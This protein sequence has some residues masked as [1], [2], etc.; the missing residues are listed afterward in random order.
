MRILYYD[1]FAGISGDMNLGALIDLGVDKDYLI[2]EL[3]KL[4]IEGF[5]LEVKQDQRRG[6]T[7][8]RA[9]VIIEN[10]ENEKH[11]HL[12][13]IE[14]LIN[15]SELT[16]QVKINAL[17]IFDLIA[18]AEAKV[19]NISKEKV[20]FHEV[21]ALDSIA[22]IVGAAIC[23]DYLK[24]D[25]ILS[26]PIQLGGGTVKCAH[27][28]M[29]VPAPA[30]A[31]IVTN[32]PVKTG[33]VNYEATTPTGAAI[34]VA[35]VDKFTDKIDLPI[36]KTAYGIGYYDTE[37]PNVLRVYLCE[38][39]ERVKDVST[40]EAFLLESN[41]DDM[42]P[43]HYDFILEQLF[44]SGAS[45]AW[46]VPIVMKKS[47][48]AVTLSILCNPI[49]VE[50]MKEII[51]TH[52][53]S[54]GIREYKINKNIL[55]REELIVD[56]IYGPIRIKQSFYKGKLVR[57]KPE[58]ADCKKLAEKHKVSISEIEKAVIKNSDK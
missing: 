15:G 58:Y 56:T 26:S 25:K 47:R 49:L 27:G 6:I 4:N 12:R 46:L 45:D 22:D 50:K 1:C 55:R 18:E 7:G 21:G 14:E 32:I 28:I 39:K 57:S 43:E 17:K 53:T 20:H 30:T 5:H 38:G 34:L 24:V 41:I 35:M 42:N 10:Q 52:S 31:L 37:V 16:E 2:T 19:H 48:P 23:L 51:F 44:K 8:T 9:K 13:H 40:E 3:K 29:P 33:L 54:I 11:R 36:T